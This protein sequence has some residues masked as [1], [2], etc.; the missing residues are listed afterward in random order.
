MPSF[1]RPLS[2]L[3]TGARAKR[4]PITRPGRSR[5]T[6][7]LLEGREVPAGNVTGLLST[8]GVLTLT[9]VNG[10]GALSNQNFLITGN[11]TDSVIVDGN[12]A[13]P[14]TIN[15]GGGPVIY[16]GIKSIVINL[17]SGSDTV[18]FDNVDLT[19]V[20]TINGGA[21][22]KQVVVGDTPGTASH[23]GSLIFNGSTGD[24]TLLIHNGTHVIDGELRFTGHNG[25]NIVSLGDTAGDTTDVGSITFKG[26][27]GF[28]ALVTG[29][30]G[31]SVH[32]PI[33]L[34]YGGGGSSTVFGSDNMT[35]EGATTLSALAGFDAVNF[36]VNSASSFASGPISLNFGDGGSTTFFGGADHE[37]NGD[38]NVTA[39]AGADNFVTVGNNFHVAG[40]FKFATGGGGSTISMGSDTTDAIDG[41]VTATHLGG[42]DVAD[43]GV[44]GNGSVSL[45]PV[46]ISNGADDGIVSFD[47]ADNTVNGDVSV[48]NGFSATGTQVVVAGGDSLNI[49]GKLT[50]NNAGAGPAATVTQL[51][52]NSA[53]SIGGPVKIT[54]AAGDDAVILGATGS[55]VTLAGGVSIT[56]FN[57]ASTTI[58]G[59]AT[60]D[61]TGDIVVSSGTGSA[62]FDASGVDQLGVTGNLTI[63]SYS[64]T[65]TLALGGANQGSIGGTLKYTTGIGGDGVAITAM[66]LH[67]VSLIL[68]NGA[69]AV[70][71]D[72][73][74]TLTGNF[75]LTAG[76]GGQAVADSASVSGNVSITTGIDGDAVSIDGSV[77]GNLS[78]LTGGGSD[79]VTVDNITVGGTT[80]INTGDQADIV[81]IDG[82]VFNGKTTVLLGNGD[83]QFDVATNPVTGFETTF[84]G[85]VVVNAGAGNDTVSVGIDG[86][87]FNRGVFNSTVT[88]DAGGGLA[89]T[90]LIGPP[91][92]N[93]FAFLP[94]LPGGWDVVI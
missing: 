16:S 69:S 60:M 84:N 23:F 83:D 52:P 68:G 42:T 32:G 8:T 39:G 3:W 48:T 24:N 6:L 89:D 51:A 66:D 25:T 81:T 93:S 12:T 30:D 88:F 76:N 5:L 54:D 43:F 34:N 72:A 85:A 79:N 19:G 18:T 37:V 73:T 56:N 22:P 91:R 27:S 21:G 59:G 64:G 65:S 87:D 45:G 9:G 20:V 63:S 10:V 2:R 4:R 94:V 28:D 78:V 35:I 31:L 14:T 1:F 92:V 29:G 15:L 7:Q 77:G 50:I 57:G 74:V 40:N 53:L 71:L 90:L 61:V 75:T 70:A 58:L 44:G 80:Y 47:G 49:S 13:D 62:L 86:D 11:G 46:T 36:G 41:T 17:Q 82:S 33:S 67:D 26:G 55:T 38:L